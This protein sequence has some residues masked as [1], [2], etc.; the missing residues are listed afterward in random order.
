MNMMN[1][2]TNLYNKML[3][4]GFYSYT[5]TF[6]DTQGENGKHWV[7]NTD[8]YKGINMTQ[9]DNTKAQKTDGTPLQD[10]N[11]FEQFL[12]NG[13]LLLETFS[14]SE[15]KFVSTSLSEDTCIQEVEDDTKI[16]IAQAQYENRDK[17][18]AYNVGPED[19]DCITT[20]ELADLFC[21]A[22]KE[23]A[24]WENL[25]TGGPHEANFLKLDCSRIRNVL[26]WKPHWDV[27][28]AVGKTV[29]WYQAYLKGENMSVFTDR[30]IR[31][32][33]ENGK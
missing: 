1:Y 30:Q 33:E 9:T 2:Y 19:R 18:G 7:Y 5:D 27:K 13:E 20:G 25:Y 17:E 4:S 29:E 26:G 12:R 15:G 23:G 31:E 21:N 22:W 24:E 3:T 8:L 14:K 16:A 11:T 28:T 6:A 10:A 32:Y